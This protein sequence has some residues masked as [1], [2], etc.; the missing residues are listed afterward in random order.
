MALIG[1]ARVST[2]DQT[3]DP[4]LDALKKV[5]CDLI[6]SDKEGGAVTLRKE[7]NEMLSVLKKGDTVVFY[8]LDRFSRSLQHL[9]ETVQL[10][11][12]KGVGVRSLTEALD[13]TTPSGVLIFHVFAAL[14]QFERDLISERTKLGLEAAR[15][16]GRIG[17]GQWRV[18]PKILS[19]MSEGEFQE[20]RRI[21]SRATYYRYLKGR[22]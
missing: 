6:Y 15:K 3:L 20:L 22:N 18:D 10:L 7:F 9:V 8:K 14:A 5:G 1:Y 19:K 12:K 11:G 2:N 13:T 4:Q 17:G 16:R 21:V